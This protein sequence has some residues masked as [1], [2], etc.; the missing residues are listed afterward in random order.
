MKSLALILT[1]LTSFSALADVQVP[2]DFPA[3]KC[4][5]LK[6]ELVSFASDLT[7]VARNKNIP[8]KQMQEGFDFILIEVGIAVSENPPDCNY[9]ISFTKRKHKEFLNEASKP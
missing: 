2:E 9:A 6:V 7:I 8:E 5:G 1:L 4:D 3:H